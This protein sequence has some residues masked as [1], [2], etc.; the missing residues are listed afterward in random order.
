MFVASLSLYATGWF[1]IDGDLKLPILIGSPF[2]GVYGLTKYLFTMFSLEQN[3]APYSAVKPIM[4]EY[5][6]DLIKDIYNNK[7]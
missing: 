6:K 3:F 2:L 4:E 7:E 1:L 5:N